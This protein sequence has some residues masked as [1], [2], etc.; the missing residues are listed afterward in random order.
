LLSAKIRYNA[1]NKK[2]NEPTNIILFSTLVVGPFPRHKYLHALLN[3]QRTIIN[4]IRFGMYLLVNKL[5]VPIFIYKGQ[6]LH[7]IGRSQVIE[8]MVY[9]Y[10]TTSFHTFPNNL[11]S[12][13]NLI[14]IMVASP[15]S[16]NIPP[17]LPCPYELSFSYGDNL[18]GKVAHTFGS[19][20]M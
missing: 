7:Q 11:S 12:D 13:P 5:V 8:L 2:E 20:E 6:S 16:S 3:K 15:S 17:W 18:L 1:L 19:S 14:S 4:S 10:N 9:F